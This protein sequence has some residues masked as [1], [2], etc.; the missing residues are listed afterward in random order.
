LCHC[1]DFF[2]EFFYFLFFLDNSSVV[3]VMLDPPGPPRAQVL[4]KMQNN[5][6]S[7]VE[8]AATPQQIP[9]ELP[10]AAA[11]TVPQIEPPSP[12]PQK[13]KGIAIISRYPNSSD[14]G[15]KI[16]NNLI[17]S[18][19]EGGPTG[20]STGNGSTQASRIVHDSTKPAPKRVHPIEN[21]GKPPLQCNEVTSSDDETNTPPVSKRSSSS[22]NMKAKFNKMK[23]LNRELAALQQ[24]HDGVSE[25]FKFIFFLLFNYFFLVMNPRNHLIFTVVYN[26]IKFL[27]I[28]GRCT[29]KT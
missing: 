29:V 6:T 1:V 2:D 19:H 16:G 23:S 8:P 24:D 4:R 28:I 17:G 5:Q 25:F 26:E 7:S 27:E 14:D 20:S 3:T 11:P 10:P 21:S 9:A 13:T 12:Q 22:A 15:A 18:T